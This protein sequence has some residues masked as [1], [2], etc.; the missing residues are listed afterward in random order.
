MTTAIISAAASIILA[1]A[2]YVFSKY[3]ERESDWRKK[4]LEMYQELFSS[5][6]GIV[7]GDSTPEAQKRFAAACN[8]IGLIASAEVITALQTFQAAAKG[9]P[10]ID[11]DEV[12]TDLLIKIRKDLKLPLSTKS[13]L[14]YRLWSSGT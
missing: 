4:K 14:T 1:A 11:H 12:L 3:R 7:K 5:I 8:T 6:S 2:G 13:K 10:D 9:V